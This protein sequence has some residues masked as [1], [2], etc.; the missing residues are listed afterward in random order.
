MADTIIT[1]AVRRLRFDA[2]PDTPTY[3]L[4]CRLADLLSTVV[5]DWS[6]G[7]YG[8]AVHAQ[9]TILTAAYVRLSDE[10]SRYNQGDI[11]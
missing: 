1:Q 9:A 3:D 7:E 5:G 8:R 4:Y 11:L 6:V 2:K 10:A